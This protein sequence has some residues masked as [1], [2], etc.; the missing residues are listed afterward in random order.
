MVSDTASAGAAGPG[1]GDHPLDPPAERFREMAAAAAEWMVSYHDTVADLPV[2]PRV[3]SADLRAELAEPLPQ[4][5]R[6]FA[7]LLD[8]FRDVIVPG[9]RHNSHPRFFGYVSAPGTA[10]ASVADFLASGLNANLTAWRSAPAP[11]EVEHVAIGWIAEALGVGPGAGG[12]FTS[13]GSVANLTA[14]AAARHRTCGDAITSGGAAAHPRP[15]R[16]YASSQA[17]HSIHKAAAVLGIGRDNVREV[18]VDDR[19]RMDVADL[20]ARIEADRAAG[21]DACA[22]V[23]SAGTVITGAVDPLADIAEVARR[24]GLWMHV[25]A[26]Y[27]GFARLA[28]SARPRFEGLAEADSIAL[29]PHKWLYLPADCGCLIYRDPRWVRGAFALDADYTRVLETEPAEA[30]AFWD[31]GPELS[32][33]FRALKVWMTLAYAGARAIGEAIESNIDCARHCADLVG[34]S[35]DLELMAPV[36]LSIV[37]FRYVPA[38][39]RGRTRSGDEEQEIDDLNQRIMHAMQRGGGS[40]VSNASIGG[41]FAL[42]ACVLN[43]RTTRRDMEILLEDVRRAAVQVTTAG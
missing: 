15:L 18:A 3:S 14:L 37:C 33:R 38:R 36:E 25:D 4:Q 12:L 9:S 11:V 24:Y 43:Y 41:R 26:C 6:D 27:G 22:V 34:A 19:L 28:P 32:R 5:G 20:V 13:G 8:T 10:V 39:L 42:R 21:A 2:A 17:H 1:S 23:A 29:D 31:Y 7:D 40:Y 16:I 35:G 30:F